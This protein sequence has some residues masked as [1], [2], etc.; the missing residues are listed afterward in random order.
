MPLQN[1]VTP[2]GEIVA[3]PQRGTMM[4]NRGI[5]HD[6]STRTLLKRRWTTRAWIICVCDFKGARR[7][8]MERRS[9][10]EL[11]FFDEAAALAAGHR[12]C[13]YCQS[14]RAKA[15]QAAWADG[16]ATPPLSAPAMD[17]ILHGERLD[18]RGGKRRHPI[19]GSLAGLPD[20]AMIAAGDDAYVIKGG[21]THLW[22]W[23]G[24]T[25]SNP[26]TDNVTLLTPPSTVRAL[27]A[28]YSPVIRLP[29]TP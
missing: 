22:S 28:G 25:L 23:N 24:Y 19:E 27:R 20:G 7:E 3:V 13:F 2:F 15:F 8:V 6:P 21:K 11:F 18:A 5:I 17:T 29:I 16:N 10:T 12:P 26:K 9:W 1:R 14:Q 4:G